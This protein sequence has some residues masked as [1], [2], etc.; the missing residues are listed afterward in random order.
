MSMTCVILH[1]GQTALGRYEFTLILLASCS[2]YLCVPEPFL[3][4]F[5]TRPGFVQGLQNQ[6]CNDGGADERGKQVS[7][8]ILLLQ[9]FVK[10]IA[11]SDVLSKLWT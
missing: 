10:V 1:N 9:I 6:G 4:S 3:F 7:L 8:S 2:K 11:F 5:S